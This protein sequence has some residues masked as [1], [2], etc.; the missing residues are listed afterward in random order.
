LGHVYHNKSLILEKT[1]KSNQAIV[2]AEKALEH[3]M[4]IA[5]NDEKW[6]SLF[7]INMG[8]SYYSKNEIIKSLEYFKR[9][10]NYAIDPTIKVTAMNMISSCYLIEGNNTE[11]LNYLKR[12]IS[13]L[14]RN[15]LDS[16]PIATIIFTSFGNYLHKFGDKQIA[17]KYLLESYELIKNYSNYSPY[18]YSLAVNS[19]ADFFLR[20]HDYNSALYY[21]QVGLI[22]Y[23]Q[24]FQELD[25]HIN[26]DL[27]D[28]KTFNK[29][30]FSTLRG[31]AQAMLYLKSP[32]DSLQQNLLT[33]IETCKI[34]IQFNNYLRT[35]SNDF[36]SFFSVLYSEETIIEIAL[37]A[38]DRLYNLTNDLT[39]LYDAFSIIESNKVTNLRTGIHSVDIFEFS[40]IPENF[41]R[42]EDR[43]R[44]QIIHLNQKID[45]F[46]IQT[47]FLDSLT[48]SQLKNLRF[49][50][51]VKYD[52]LITYLEQKYP[53]YYELKYE[54]KSPSVETIQKKLNPKS[55][56]INYSV[57]DTNI[58]IACVSSDNYVL[59]KLSIDSSF[60][61]NAMKYYKLIK[62]GGDRRQIKKL[63][64]FLYSKLITPIEHF[65]HE[66]EN[67]IVIPDNCLYY[68]PFETLCKKDS[69]IKEEKSFHN[70]NY[71][72]RNYT[73]SYHYSA[74]LWEKGDNSYL[75]DSLKLNDHKNFIG[76]AP[77]S[78]NNYLIPNSHTFSSGYQSD[79]GILRSISSD[80]ITLN[81]LPFS[82][83]EVKSIAELY[84]SMGY[85][86]VSILDDNATETNFKKLI[87]DCKAVHIATHA[88]SNDEKP[89]FSGMVFSIPDYRGINFASDTSI[90]INEFKYVLDAEDDGILH[91]GEMYNLNLSADLVVLSGCETGIGK[92][93]QGEGMIAMTRGLLYSGANNIVYTL[94]KISDAHTQGF[95]I[96]F[97]S[98]ILNGSSYSQALRHAK[99]QMISN[100]STSFPKL[101]SGYMLIGQ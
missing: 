35:F 61:M 53:D 46:D 58:F 42:K 84:N 97:Y 94:W 67:L 88:F 44:R 21:Y 14:K 39:Y 24:T 64:Y 48:V 17:L 80:G 50:A 54:T 83:L 82:K 93:V 22:N 1:G 72:I 69:Q 75:N 62:K 10:L 16:S 31:K 33:C 29:A 27:K 12:S 47:K 45:E 98:Q 59:K 41:I 2:Y 9:S 65:I 86:G 77:V 85:I 60:H 23:F 99:L 91:A 100:P 40:E 43:L 38:Y 34:A 89:E 25:I 6:L 5:P 56:L 26:P 28:L 73:V 74:D 30:L 95:M 52:S 96:D 36:N 8:Y 68:I 70:L 57:F 51:M 3:H 101:W 76:F 78:E 55:A 87:K 71:L 7:F 13:T 66:K 90:N 49:K 20:E 19:L 4:R 63:S 18:T 11:A 37:T 15:K 92:L 81:A 79:Q 32:A